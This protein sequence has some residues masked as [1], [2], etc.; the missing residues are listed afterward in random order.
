MTYHSALATKAANN[1]QNGW[2]LADSFTALD[3]EGDLL[4]EGNGIDMPGVTQI[5]VC[6]A[7]TAWCNWFHNKQGGDNFPCGTNNCDAPTSV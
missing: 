2:A 3:N 1:G 5:P 6:D 4:L 7:D